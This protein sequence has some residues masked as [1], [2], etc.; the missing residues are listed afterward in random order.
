[1]VTCEPWA[2]LDFQNGRSRKSVFLIF[3][4]SFG[5]SRVRNQESYSTSTY[6]LLLDRFELGLASR[7]QSGVPQA[8]ELVAVTSSELFY[9]RFY[10]DIFQDSSG[11]Y[12]TNNGSGG[13]SRVSSG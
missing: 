10:S 4:A 8:T 5:S 12:V 3:F 7:D 13:T 6:A 11:V 9:P 1:M 2:L